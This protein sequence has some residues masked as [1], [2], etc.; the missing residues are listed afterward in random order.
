MSGRLRKHENVQFCVKRGSSVDQS[1]NSKL[2]QLSRDPVS[3]YKG[4]F[5]KFSIHSSFEHT[6]EGKYGSY[7][8]NSS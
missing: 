7:K 3:I 5:L 4:G 6:L 8:A 2:G 1:E